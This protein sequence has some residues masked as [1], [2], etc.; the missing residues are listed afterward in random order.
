MRTCMNEYAFNHYSYL[1]CIYIYCIIFRH[2][3]ML[4]GYRKAKLFKEFYIKRYTLCSKSEC[5]CD[6]L[7]DI[8]NRFLFDSY[9]LYDLCVYIFTKSDR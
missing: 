8:R 1:V 7:C 4:F 2:T 3:D 6:K 5:F 9:A